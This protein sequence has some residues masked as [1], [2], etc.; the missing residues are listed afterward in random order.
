MVSD[1]VHIILTCPIERNDRKNLT[2]GKNFIK[3]F[4]NSA[5]SKEFPSFKAYEEYKILPILKTMVQK[6]KLKADNNILT[7]LIRQVGPALRDLNTSL[8][9]IKLMIHPDN[10]ITAEVG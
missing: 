7:M 5:Q 1:R 4:K 2:Q 6:A 10:V 8:D 3:L 9:K